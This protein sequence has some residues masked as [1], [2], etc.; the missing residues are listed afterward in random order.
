MRRRRWLSAIHF[1]GRKL[2]K[3]WKWETDQCGECGHVTARYKVYASWYK[4]PTPT[5]IERMIEGARKRFIE[6]YGNRIFSDGTGYISN[7]TV[8][9]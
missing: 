7:L 2:P 3:T 9:E 1:K 8:P 6:N 4:Q 5:E